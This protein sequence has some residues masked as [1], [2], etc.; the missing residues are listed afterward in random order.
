MPFNKYDVKKLDSDSV[1][2]KNISDKPNKV[3][4]YYK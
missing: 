3:L 2:L 4:I 1:K